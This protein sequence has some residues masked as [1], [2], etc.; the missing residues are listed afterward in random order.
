[1]LQHLLNNWFL[2]LDI[3]KMCAAAAMLAAVFVLLLLIFYCLGKRG[4]KE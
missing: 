1:M 4:G 3:Q 2:S